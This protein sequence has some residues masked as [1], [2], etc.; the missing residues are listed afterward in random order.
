MR[1]TKSLLGLPG[2]AEGWPR[3]RA[4][5]AGGQPPL[6]MRRR[7]HLGRGWRAPGPPLGALRGG[8]PPLYG[9]CGDESPGSGSAAGL[10]WP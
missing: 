9:C 8:E 6:Q 3:A 2:L 4:R 1:I 7:A 10:G 5:R